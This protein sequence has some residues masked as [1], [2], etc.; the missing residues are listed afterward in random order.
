MHF[1][2]RQTSPWEHC[3]TMARESQTSCR[4]KRR[5]IRITLISWRIRCIWQCWLLF[6]DL[7][8]KL[9]GLASPSRLTSKR[10]AL[11]TGRPLRWFFHHHPTPSELWQYREVTAARH[12]I[13]LRKQIRKEK[14]RQRPLKRFTCAVAATLLSQADGIFSYTGGQRTALGAFLCGVSLSSV[15]HGLFTSWRS[16][17]GHELLGHHFTSSKNLVDSRFVQGSPLSKASPESLSWMETWD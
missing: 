11:S 14:K 7:R 15:V 12:P 9:Q 3:P 2:V 4:L 17:E 1:M 8:L 5:D 6:W 13:K 16:F 10:Q